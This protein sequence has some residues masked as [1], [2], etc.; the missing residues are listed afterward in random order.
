VF[1]VGPKG[2][3]VVDTGISYRAGVEIQAAVRRVTRQPIRLV[4]L[5][6]PGQEAIFGAAAFQAHGIPILMHR[7]A[8]ALMASRC[9]SCLRNL[10]ASLGGDAMAETR[11]VVPDRL[12]DGDEA[13]VEIG[14]RLHVFAP[15][16]SSAPGALA[17]FDERTST[18]IAGSLVSIRSVPDMRDA[19]MNGW[20]DAL[21]MLAATHCRH[22]VST[23]G[24]VG[25]C[26]DI[27]AFARYFDDLEARVGALL[28]EGTGLAELGARC[29]L[30]RYASWDRYEDLHLANASRAYL[31]LERDLFHSP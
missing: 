3:A 2:V 21:A 10:A 23:F 15:P 14:R 12:I 9:E 16:W 8:A 29:D 5:T 13:I 22:L 7:D 1:V 24:A 6:H 27:A 30:P 11:V 28:R 31:R 4:I 17:V 18:L 20:H 25:R 19:D 26:S